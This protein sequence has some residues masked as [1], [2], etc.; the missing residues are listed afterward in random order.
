MR[1]AVLFATLACAGAAVATSG[2]M[3]GCNSSGVTPV[4]TYADGAD[5]PEAGC[6]ELIPLEGSTGPEGEGGSPSETGVPEAS[7]ADVVTPT[8]DAHV[9][10]AG[11]DSAAPVD[12]G[13]ADA[14]DAS[15]AQDAKDAKG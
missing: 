8:P 9:P 11:K 3:G 4:C 2:A 5:D 15:D 10:D 13:E 6:G 1:L 12:A 14:H 7:P